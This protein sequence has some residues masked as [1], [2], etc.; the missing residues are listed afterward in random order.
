MRPIASASCWKRK[1]AA[2][3]FAPL[4]N[5]QASSSTKPYNEATVLRSCEERLCIYCSERIKRKAILCPQMFYK[6]TKGKVDEWKPVA[7]SLANAGDNRSAKTENKQGRIRNMKRPDHWTISTS[8]HIFHMLRGWWKMLTPRCVDK[9]RYQV[10]PV[11]HRCAF[12]EFLE[13]ALM[14]TTVI[15]AWIRH[16]IFNIPLDWGD[17]YL[18]KMKP[19]PEHAVCVTARDI[20]QK[21]PHEGTVSR[22]KTFSPRTYNGN[23][24]SPMSILRSMKTLEKLPIALVTKNFAANWQGGTKNGT[25][26]LKLAFLL[27]EQVLSDAIVGNLLTGSENTRLARWCPQQDQYCW[28]T[29][30]FVRLAAIHVECTDKYLLN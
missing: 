18:P 17:L 7:P 10:M 25:I 20:P 13:K 28:R 30:W 5:S 12:Y 11:P 1:R 4:L 24:I 21:C 3:N 23:D 9:G 27:I 2:W 16:L 14:M 6:S 19:L 29:L 22:S 15:V 8:M 26:L